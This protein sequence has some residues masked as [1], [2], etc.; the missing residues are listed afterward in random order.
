MAEK[1]TKLAFEKYYDDNSGVRAAVSYDSTKDSAVEI[2]SVSEEWTAS[3]PVAD[4]D[5]LIECLHR[6]KAEL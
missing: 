5:W 2:M 3:F 1:V 4:I 6:V